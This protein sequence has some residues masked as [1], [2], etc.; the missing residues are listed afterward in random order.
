MT[1]IP[2]RD[3]VSLTAFYKAV[4]GFAV[5]Q[6]IEAPGFAENIMMPPDGGGAA[7]VLMHQDGVV[8][9]S[10]GTQLVFETKDI[11]AFATRVKESGGQMTHLI[12]TV[13]SLGLSYAFFQD[14]E[15]NTIEAIMR[16]NESRA[17]ADH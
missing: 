1:K 10:G 4:V 17:S 5:A 2:T 16:M 11:G 7:L 6:S 9:A 8:P 12:E 15:G 3:L 14:P 13:P